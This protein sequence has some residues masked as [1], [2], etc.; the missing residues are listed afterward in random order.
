MVAN[1]GFGGE[2]KSAPRLKIGQKF[3]KK[4]YLDNFPLF[5]LISPSFYHISAPAPSGSPEIHLPVKNGGGREQL[6]PLCAPDHYNTLCPFG[7][8]P[9]LFPH[10]IFVA[11]EPRKKNHCSSRTTKKPRKATAQVVKDILN[12]GALTIF[13]PPE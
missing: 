8:P 1:P 11:P 6:L 12:K 9:R 4:S 5:L 7:Y 3:E 10:H 13:N 2:G